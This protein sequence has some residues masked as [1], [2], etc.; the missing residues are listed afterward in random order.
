MRTGELD[1]RVQERLA[2]AVAADKRRRELQTDSSVLAHLDE[3][4]DVDELVLD[5]SFDEDLATQVGARAASQRPSLNQRLS[6][7]SQG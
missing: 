6:I 4:C 7:Q 5:G 2:S 1:P 3:G